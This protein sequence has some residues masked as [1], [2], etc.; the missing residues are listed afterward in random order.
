MPF[1]LLTTDRPPGGTRLRFAPSPTGFFHV[2]SARTALYNWLV[3]RQSGGTFVLRIE[4]SDAERGH[5]DWVEGILDSLA[6]L[7]LDWDEGPVFQ[8]ERS[9]LYAAAAEQ[10]WAA[11]HAYWCD[12]TRADIEARAKAAGRP[13]GYDGFCRERALGPGAGRALRFATP[14]QGQTTVADR[15]RGEVSFANA[16]IED[17][18]LLRSNGSPLFLLCNVVDD[19]SQR[20]TEVIRG[21]DHL[22]NTPKYQLL[23]AALGAGG[24]PSFAH[25]PMLV[26]ERR[27][28]LSKRRDPVALENYRHDGYLPAAMLNYLALLGWG[29]EDGQEV[30][31]LP[32][33]VA[34]FSIE[35]VNH[36]PAYF[37]L[38]KLAHFNGVWIRRLGTG[39]F[40]E[41]S[42]PFLR[43]QPWF[44]GGFDP[45]V[46]AA[47]AP[48]VQERVATLG[49]VPKMVSFLFCSQLDFDERSWEKIERDPRAGE[50]L[51]AAAEAFGPPAFSA[52]KWDP[53][54]LEA[55]ARAL[56]EKL[57]LSLRKAQA[58][59]RVALTGTSVGPPLFESMAAL[60]Q[61]RTLARLAAAKERLRGV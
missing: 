18:V 6:W 28:K 56:S 35:R 15:I 22:P 14:R 3:A 36:S 4:D 46:F 48:L 24:L 19:A 29:P 2:G 45:G 31:S 25:L 39:E 17:F 12:C 49:E 58:P 55:A 16:D 61:E 42:L 30:L 26:N 53:A 54:S 7:G 11:G 9:E 23:W 40:A 51:A 47:M 27:Q 10:L 33:L 8:S 34:R 1:Q 21:E 38:A 41:A 37:D 57:G 20:I 13:P 32:E 50:I 5:P 59:I 43:S 60:G 52:G 44:E